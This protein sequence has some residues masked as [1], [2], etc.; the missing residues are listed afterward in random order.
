[1]VSSVYPVVSDGVWSDLVTEKLA[2]K[3]VSRAQPGPGSSLSD[4]T[5]ILVDISISASHLSCPS[6]L[7]RYSQ[8]NELTMKC[9]IK[10]LS[11]HSPPSVD[12]QRVDLKQ[13]QL[14]N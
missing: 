3:I 1:M 13:F 14:E 12:I 6:S 4:L 10:H 8:L 11:I 2:G 9:S 5:Y 7:S